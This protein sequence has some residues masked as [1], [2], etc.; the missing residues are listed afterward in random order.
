MVEPSAFDGILFRTAGLEG[1]GL[2]P[3][4]Y[5]LGFV[6]AILIWIVGSI[7]G[8]FAPIEDKISFIFQGIPVTLFLTV[9]SV[10][11][12]FLLGILLALLK[13]SKISFLSAIA[14][15]YTSLFRGT[16]L[17]VQLFL[18][19]YGS[20]DLTNALGIEPIDAFSAAILTFSLNSAAYVSET[21]RGGILAVD[22]GQRDAAMSL[23]IPYPLMMW[24][25][26]RPQALKNILPALM[27]ELINLFKDTAQTSAIGTLVILRRAD[28]IAKEKF[29]SFPPLLIAAL[30]YYI[31]ISTMTLLA[32]F[33][34][35]RLRRSD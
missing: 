15:L 31:V 14:D 16:P 11:A 6:L 29:V 22:K 19:Y 18:I 25:I 8:Y 33:Y 4:G 34:E 30:I 9:V 35:R 24:D 27:N 12:G 28:I 3:I 10:F 21:I 7:T 32:G 20:T 13:I 23:G 5:L 26:I 2:L 17:I 1:Q